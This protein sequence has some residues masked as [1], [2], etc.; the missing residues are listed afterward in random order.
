MSNS[1]IVLNLYTVELIHVIT[2][3]MVDEC[4][5]KYIMCLSTFIIKFIDLK[6]MRENDFKGVMVAVYNSVNDNTNNTKDHQ[7]LLLTTKEHLM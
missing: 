4:D 6:D 2:I 7:N 3:K 1:G 5:K